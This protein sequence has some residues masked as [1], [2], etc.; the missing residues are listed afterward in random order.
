MFQPPFPRSYVSC[1]GKRLPP[2]AVSAV[3]RLSVVTERAKRLCC[4]AALGGVL[5]L[6]IGRWAAAQA[7]GEGSL[8]AEIDV[9]LD[10]ASYVVHASALLAADQ[11]L[12]WETLTDYERL[13][14]F[15]P[16]VMRAHILERAGDRLVIEQVGVF[17]LPFV[18]LPVRLHLAVEHTPYVMVLARLAAPPVDV[19]E[20]TLRNFSGRYRLQAI[21]LSRRAGVR[22]DYDAQFEFARP[23]PPVIGSLFGVA[24]VRRTMHEQFTAMLREIERRQ[25][26]LDAGK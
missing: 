22:L 9:S 6:G 3:A 26:L 5:W 8:A 24:A 20:P 1:G 14:E 18:D 23:L 25:A 13:R 15:V 10:G 21:P 17:S 16:G 19:G 7:T 4:C 11:R 2:N 12:V